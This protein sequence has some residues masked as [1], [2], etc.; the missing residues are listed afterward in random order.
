MEKTVEK[1][2]PVSGSAFDLIFG[3]RSLPGSPIGVIP[4][5]QEISSR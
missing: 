4:E 5:T 3:R 1:A 2:M